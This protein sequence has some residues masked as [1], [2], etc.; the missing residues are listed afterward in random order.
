MVQNQA[1]LGPMGGAG[2]LGRVR[3]LHR[4]GHIALQSRDGPPTAAGGCQAVGGR[5][6]SPKPEGGKE[7]APAAAALGRPASHGLA[8][9]PLSFAPS[10]RSP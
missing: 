7:E 6:D 3:A 2:R 8:S 5:H 10:L 9:L 1:L 4:L